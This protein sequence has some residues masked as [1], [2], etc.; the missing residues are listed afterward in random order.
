[1][2]VVLHDATC[3]SWLVGSRYLLL[4][5]DCQSVVT[6]AAVAAAAIGN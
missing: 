2:K 4:W 6:A 5:N 1:M 3:L